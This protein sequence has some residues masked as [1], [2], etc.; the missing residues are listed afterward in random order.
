[1]SDKREFF[2]TRKMGKV[3]LLACGERS[4]RFRPALDVGPEECEE[5][6]GRL[7]DAV[8]ELP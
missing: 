4:I 2:I 3:L 6:V 1:M 5:A 7:R 8:R